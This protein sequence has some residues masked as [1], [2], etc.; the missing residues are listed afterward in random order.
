MQRATV[1]WYKFILITTMYVSYYHVT[2]CT[3]WDVSDTKNDITY[4]IQNWLAAQS[5]RVG[6][7]N[8]RIVWLLEDVTAARVAVLQVL[9]MK[10]R[11]DT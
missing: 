7:A 6:I 1:S 4:F 2:M 3:R 11:S 9:A 10:N 8:D 5:I